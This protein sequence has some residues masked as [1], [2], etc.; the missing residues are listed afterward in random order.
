MGSGVLFC[1]H[2]RAVEENMGKNVTKKK[3]KAQ[4]RRRYL[5]AGILGLLVA[6]GLGTMVGMAMFN[7]S[8]RPQRDMKWYVRDSQA[9][10][11]APAS[12]AGYAATTQRGNANGPVLAVIDGEVT[13]RPTIKPTMAPALVTEAPEGDT[14]SAGGDGE[15][16]GD[17]DQASE[18]FDELSDIDPQIGEIEM[19]GDEADSS[20]TVMLKIT[21][22]GDCT[23]GGEVGSK[24]RRRFVDLANKEGYDYF[25]DGVRDVFEND[26]LTIV[27]LE[28]PLTNWDKSNKHGFVFKG[29]PEYVN[30]LAGSSVELCNLANNHTMD[31][32]KTGLKDTVNVLETAKIGYCGYSKTY[33]TTIK[34][35]RVC[36]L[37]FTWWDN[38]KKEIAQAIQNARANCDLLIV[39]IHWGIEGNTMQD[40]KQVTIGHAII[41]AGADLV[42]GTHPHVYQ[43]IEKYKGK[44]IVYS[45]GNFC[46]AGNAN[47]NDKRCLIF[48]QTFSFNPGMGIAQA[49]IM[50]AGINII[51]C[52]VS[53]V[54]NLNDF[55][56]TIMPAKEGGA[57][58]KA[59]ASRSTN[60]SLTNALWM[61]DNYVVTAGLANNGEDGKAQQPATAEIE[62]AEGDEQAGQEAGETPSDA[63]E[64]AP[65]AQTDE[66]MNT[67]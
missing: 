4:Q 61:K 59:I 62:A 44:Y 8:A 38:D 33:T 10:V 48:Q 53:S 49:N 63:P 7:A 40:H 65:A 57:M 45:L 18:V 2:W 19:A 47:P 42:I 25:F 32:G 60:F 20:G 14:A 13:P 3:N 22:A 31:Y 51:P 54:K 29:D 26:D 28:G 35:V 58:L 5:R 15:V 67:L 9:Q 17:G 16:Y 6:L 39:N 41:D 56:P 50:D 34:G 64:E 27:N 23:F 43:G 12:G 11:A 24:G 52:T 66:D 37:G 46:F 30:I 55:Q 21:A 1:A 36:A